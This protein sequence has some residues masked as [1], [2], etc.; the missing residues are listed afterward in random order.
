MG[1]VVLL[2]AWQNRARGELNGVE[3][4]PG[5][6]LIVGAGFS[7]TAGLPL[8][9]DFTEHLLD[10][11]SLKTDGPSVRQVEFLRKFVDDTFNGGETTPSNQWP[12]LEDIF[13]LV[14]LSAN[15]G[16]HLGTSYS[17]AKLRL[18]RRAMIVRIV[19]MLQ[20]D[21]NRYLRSRSAESKLLNTLFDELNA[22]NTAVLSMNWDMVIE[23]GVA[24]RQRIDRIDYGCNASDAV[25]SKGEVSLRPAA[26]PGAKTLRLLKPHGSINWLYC[27]ACR[28][29]FWVK[30]DQTEGV[31][32]T[33]FQARDWNAMPNLDPAMEIP[34]SYE[35][36]CPHCT[37]QALGT[38]IATFSFRKALDFPM[39]AA[40]W[41][42]AE[43]HLKDAPRWVFF[44]YSMPAAD[45]EFKHL[46]KR[47]QLT[48]RIKPKITV[49]TGGGTRAAEDTLVRYRKFFGNDAIERTFTGGLNQEVIDYLR[50]I[51]ALKRPS[52]KK[53]SKVLSSGA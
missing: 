10:T 20:Q 28:E 41:R 11:A 35:P 51:G 49:I 8:A 30:P 39:H 52:K 23:R 4:D 21:Y 12:E 32:R 33:L 37:A 42:T 5:V 14:D 13:T 26:P 19:R 18:V 17:A 43:S 48:E 6:L 31:A 29:L 2:A 45:F 47:I 3:F 38:R 53:P 34:K 25:F 27:D 44:G 22:D 50:K 1:L 24:L 16:H 9:S 40:T 46:L 15:T 36:H 7:K